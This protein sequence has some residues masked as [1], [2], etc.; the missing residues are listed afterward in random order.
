MRAWIVLVAS[1]A[2]LPLCLEACDGDD[3]PANPDALADASSSSGSGASS[4]SSGSSGSSSSSGS[5]GSSGD[6]AAEAGPP[7]GT[8]LYGT[9]FPYLAPLSDAVPQAD[10]RGRYRVIARPLFEDDAARGVR[11]TWLEQAGSDGLAADFTSSQPTVLTGARLDDEGNAYVSFV[12]RDTVAGPAGSTI[13]PAQAGT[14]QCA[15]VRIGHDTGSVDWVRRISVGASAMGEHTVACSVRRVFGERVLVVGRFSSS[16]ARIA[17]LATAEPAFVSDHLDTNVARADGLVAAFDLTGALRVAQSFNAEPAG[18]ALISD[19]EY[20]SA[21]EIVAVGLTTSATLRRDRTGPALATSVGA[22]AGFESTVVSLHLGDDTTTAEIW[23][24]EPQADAGGS[25]DARGSALA[26]AGDAHGFAVLGATLGSPSL[27]RVPSL[28][29]IPVAADRAFLVGVGA[30]GARRAYGYERPVEAHRLALSRDPAGRL[31]AS[32]LQANALA[33]GPSCALPASS[34]AGFLAVFADTSA[35]ACNSVRAYTGL[36]P[37]DL[38]AGA[39]SVMWTGLTT[40]G[41]DF[42]ELEVVVTAGAAAEAVVVQ[43]AP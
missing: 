19:A 36:W 6:G 24:L 1:T 11:V 22:G 34:T 18:S 4:G 5:S 42:G 13:A 30:D 17:E 35:A 15:I 21:S 32:G 39:G 3:P 28:A 9:H 23:S 27:L 7:G 14:N 20:L 26:V 31:I 37:A 12:Y 43:I 38:A 29:P 8:I 10:L 33:L 25:F 2:A 40:S 16:S 41:V